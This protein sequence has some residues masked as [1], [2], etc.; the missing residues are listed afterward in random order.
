MTPA[1][2]LIVEDDPI[3]SGGLRRN[4]VAEHHA[5]M[6][7][8][9]C[10]EAMQRVTEEH[11]DVV[12]VDLSLPDG[13][14]LD[15]VSNIRTIDR[16]IGIV[17]LTGS[18]AGEDMREALRRGASSY[19]RKPADPL[20]V[21]A[22]VSIA[23]THATWPGPKPA[24]ASLAGPE[25]NPGCVNWLLEQ[26][27]FNQLP[28]NLAKQVSHAWDLRHVETGAH[29]R[30]MSEFV[31]RLAVEVG[32][33]AVESERLGRVAM[34]HDIGKIAIPDAILTKP[35][36]LTH[37]EFA[38]MKQHAAIGGELLSGTGHPLLDLASQVA[39]SHHE[40]WNGNGYPD[41]LIG[42]ECIREARIVGIADVFDAL[43][44]TRCYK[45]S[46]PQSRVM[47]FF[48]AERGKAFEPMLVEALLDLV[49]EL[50]AVRT[51]HPDPH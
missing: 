23:F 32:Y 49:P 20:T 47:D 15:L 14:G 17:V 33:P 24:D 6:E 1:R 9:S 13:S 42:T 46:W 27:P 31:R 12:I 51:E 38:I 2:V 25:S 10:A 7:A 26:L 44:Q 45:P 22:Q 50:E 3:A 4:L 48:R 5:V 29:V 40:R 43:R 41:G 18:S 16:R 28:F 19:L 39:R 34:L 8:A 30:R 21:E 35:S 11:P 37:E 36:E